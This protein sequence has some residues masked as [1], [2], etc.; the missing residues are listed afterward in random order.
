MASHGTPP[1][2][3]VLTEPDTATARDS[4]GA[5]LREAEP[6]YE[7]L[8]WVAVNERPLAGLE[9]TLSELDPVP[10][11]VAFINVGSKPL[12]G[13][14]SPRID[15]ADASVHTATV[16][17]FS[18]HALHHE[19]GAF[20]DEGDVDT[21]TACVL[22]LAPLLE[23]VG[24]TRTI[25]FL[26]LLNSA[27]R[28][29]SAIPYYQLPR[30]TGHEPLTDQT[31]IDEV[32]DTSGA[33]PTDRDEGLTDRLPGTMKVAS[34]GPHR[35]ESDRPLQT[36]QAW[37]PWLWVTAIVTFGLG[38]IFT[39]VTALEGGV[40]VEASPIAADIIA[41]NGLGFIYIVKAVMFG[42]FFLLWAVSPNDIRVG[43]PL[44]L[45]LLGVGVL[46]WN[47]CVILLGITL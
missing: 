38:D 40:A 22:P 17:P 14:L 36:L 7:R 32:I 5:Q 19:I 42:L 9:A 33:T 18:L 45:S 47:L 3:L 43:V 24:R 31:L 34:M 15:L 11:T 2:R 12:E 44:G 29:A 28:D 4:V 35:L 23:E 20:L 6:P 8:L 16:A 46:V 30:G 41:A 25:H 39:T 10:S 37:T 13:D 21:N 1:S 26:K 27:F